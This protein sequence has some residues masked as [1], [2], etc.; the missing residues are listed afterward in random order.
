MRGLD[1]VVLDAQIIEQKFDREIVVGFDP[2]D[3]GRGENNDRRL[4]LEHE[5]SH[6]LFVAEIELRPVASRQVVKIFRFE[7]SKQR[8]A[9]QAAMTRDEDFF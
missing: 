9:N 2:A 5:F 6:G 8:A 4:F 3:F 7:S 1:D